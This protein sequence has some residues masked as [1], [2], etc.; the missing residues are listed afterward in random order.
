MKSDVTVIVIT[1]V[2]DRIF[3]LV[4]LYT[5]PR[6]GF[7]PP[8]RRLDSPFADPLTRTPEVPDSRRTEGPAGRY[9]GTKPPLLPLS[10]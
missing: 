3:V 5:T 4:L 2:S 7:R 6:R 10:T 1:P 9:M 8:V